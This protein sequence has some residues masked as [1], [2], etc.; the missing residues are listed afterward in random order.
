MWAV[1]F[2]VLFGSLSHLSIHISKANLRILRI[3]DSAPYSL[4]FIAFILPFSLFCRAKAMY[5]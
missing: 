5:W 2:D 3:L 1:I 4:S